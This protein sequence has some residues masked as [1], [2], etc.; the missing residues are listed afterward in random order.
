MK[1]SLSVG[2]SENTAQIAALLG[3]FTFDAVRN[4]SLI[5]IDEPHS[6]IHAQDQGKFFQVCCR[7]DVLTAG[8]TKYVGFTSPERGDVHLTVFPAYKDCYDNH[9]TK[10]QIYERSEYIEGDT[11]EPI[12]RNRQRGATAN[13]TFRDNPAVLSSG[14]LI[15]EECLGFNNTERRH[16]NM[17][18]ILANSTSYL[19]KLTAYAISDTFA[20][21]NIIFNFYEDD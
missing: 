12:D 17:E 15:Y 2:G 6:Y 20:Y 13:T 10:M 3:Q 11:L 19:V 7:T 9:V 5:T 16:Q 21:A 18:F 1:M 8:S 14:N 4:K